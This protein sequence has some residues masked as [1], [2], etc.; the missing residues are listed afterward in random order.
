M[1]TCMTTWWVGGL[2]LALLVVTLLGPGAATLILVLSV[3]YLPGFARVTYAEVLA[4]WSDRDRSDL[5]RL[6][7]RL[8]ESLDSNARKHGPVVGAPEH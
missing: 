7:T 8:N 1:K 2:L 3:L 6:L 5:A 4:E